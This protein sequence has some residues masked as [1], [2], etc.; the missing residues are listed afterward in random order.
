M[1]VVSL[2]P[3]ATE[4]VAAL[5]AEG[6]LAGI[7][8]ECDW[9]PSVRHL[10]RVTATPTDSSSPSGPGEG[11][12]ANVATCGY[13]APMTSVGIRNLKN[14]LS[15]YVRRVAAGERVAVTDR[16]RVVAE[17]VPPTGG[18]TGAERSRYRDLVAAGLIRPALEGGDPL[19]DLPS[20]R[21][22]PGTAAALIDQDRGEP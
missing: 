3:A 9:P 6:S 22:P 10:P 16:G 11:R 13:I 19:A 17:L 7:S 14:H 5:G 20:L 8:H 1:R 18:P 21:L 12:I 15:R 2:L 4:M